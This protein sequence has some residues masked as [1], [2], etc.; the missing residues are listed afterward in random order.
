MATKAQVTIVS[1]LGLN[2]KLWFIRVSQLAYIVHHPSVKTVQLLCLRF[3]PSLEVLQD[4]RG[5]LEAMVQ[6]KHISGVQ[7]VSL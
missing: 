3:F 1:L 5:K 7:L 6:Y 4:S 2:G